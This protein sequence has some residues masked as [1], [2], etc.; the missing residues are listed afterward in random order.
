MR[1]EDQRPGVPS[2]T[3]RV[4]LQELA[5]RSLAGCRP[6]TITAVLETAR[7]RTVQPGDTIYA[8]G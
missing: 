8:Q 6:E 3:Q 2:T 7:V 5:T 4:L 1:L